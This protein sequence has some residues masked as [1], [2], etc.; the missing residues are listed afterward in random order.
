MTFVGLWTS[1]TTA[2]A[3]VFVELR[4]EPLGVVGAEHV[5]SVLRAL[6]DCAY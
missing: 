4:G 5:A 3:I 6:D 2:H 1:A